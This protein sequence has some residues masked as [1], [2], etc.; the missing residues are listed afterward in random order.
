MKNRKDCFLL[1]CILLKLFSYA[2]ELH[3]ICSNIFGFDCIPPI[4]NMLLEQRQVPVFVT[5]VSLFL[6][7]R[8]WLHLSLF[9]FFFNYVYIFIALAI[10]REFP[11]NRSISV[12]LCSDTESHVFH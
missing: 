12:E 10:G 7:L 11:A 6:V 5:Q 1:S 3:F 4:R 8:R 9:F 2:Y